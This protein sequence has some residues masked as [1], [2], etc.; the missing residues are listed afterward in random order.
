MR[1]GYIIA[2]TTYVSYPPSSLGRLHIKELPAG[3][4]AYQDYH[5]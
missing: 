1:S 3:R 2:P 5:T 4:V